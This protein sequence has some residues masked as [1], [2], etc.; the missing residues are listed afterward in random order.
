M[1]LRDIE[2]FAVLAEHGQL[3]RAA[4]ALGLSQPALSLSLRRLE[5]SAQAKL[6]RR[7]PKGVELTDVGA[8]L[9]THVERLRLA[10]H[11]LAREVADLAQGTAGQLRVGT[12]PATADGFL[13]LACGTFMTDAPKVTLTVSV[14]ATTDSLL[15]LLRKGDL[16]VVVN[17]IATVPL[18]D[19]VLEPLWND[20]FVVY[21]SLRHPLAKRKSVTLA[22]LSGERWACTTA[23]AYQ[24][25]QSLQRTFEEH[26]LPSPRFG[27]LS[28][29]VMLRHRTVSAT[30]LIGI[31]SRGMVE[32]NADNLG[33]KIIPVKDV[34]W[35]RPV[36]V[37]YRKDGYLSPAARRFIEIL[38]ATAKKFA[39]K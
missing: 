28:D 1:D 18:Q 22:R 19:L 24:A 27:L 12:G 11:D 9:L 33:L 29:S 4:E 35:I 10:R 30:G 31:G 36:A 13:P 3:V 2:Y 21:A 16:D 37:V 8:A 23:S 34:K 38:K 39:G 5:K 26:G 7:T 32:A 25:W 17:H 15:P 20:E 6:V 14:A